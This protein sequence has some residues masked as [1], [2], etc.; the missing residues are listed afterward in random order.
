MSRRGSTEHAQD[1]G[2]SP[3]ASPRPSASSPPVQVTNVIQ[4]ITEHTPQEYSAVLVYIADLKEKL[5]VAER[6][7][8]QLERIAEVAEAPLSTTQHT[9]HSP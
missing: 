8:V 4:I 6:Y 1:A 9:H 5:E 7:R 2:S 3:S